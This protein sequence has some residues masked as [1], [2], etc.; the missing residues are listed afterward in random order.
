[1]KIS[2][3]RQEYQN[4]IDDREYYSIGEALDIFSKSKSKNFDESIDIAINLGID[5]GKSLSLIH[6]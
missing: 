2:K 3:K 6:I 1:M 5:A 4:M